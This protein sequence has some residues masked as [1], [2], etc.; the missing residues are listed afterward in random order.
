MGA[1]WDKDNIGQYSFAAGYGTLARGVGS[2]SMGA[3]NSSTGSY[4]VSLGADNSSIGDASVSFGNLNLAN[5]K[6][7]MVIGQSSWAKNDFSFCGGFQSVA[8]GDYSISYGYISYATGLRSI[9]LG[10]KNVARGRVQLQWVAITKAIGGYA[11]SLGANSTASGLFSATLGSVN[12]ALG[13]Y[14][15]GLGSENTAVADYSLALGTTNVT[16]GIHSATLGYGNVA[17][18]SYSLV[19]GSYN[20]STLTDKYFEIGNGTFAARSNAFTVLKNGNVG[21]GITNPTNLLTFAAIGGKKISLFP[22]GTG[23]AG[24]GIFPNEFRQYSDNPNADITFG[25]DSYSTGFSEKV[26]FKASGM[27]GVGTATPILSTG[28]SGMVVQNNTYIQMRVQSSASAAGMEFKPS[29]GN[30]Y[31]IQADNSNNWFVYNRNANAYRLFINGSGF[32]GIGTNNPTQALQ[33]IGNILASGTITPSDI[34][35]KKNIQLIESPMEKLKQLNGVTYEYR[36][37][38]FPQMGF[39]DMEQVGL[40]AQEVEKVF[41]QLVVTDDKGYKAV[42]YVKLVPVLIE[43]TKAQQSQ[44]DKQQQQIEE[45]QKLVKQLMHSK[46]R[47]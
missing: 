38:D 9:S 2:V 5:G 25:Y 44:I 10:D 22:G 12:V 36:K 7:S 30:Q 1:T 15:I 6:Y 17:Q 42:D 29:T 27:V 46:T 28:A 8:S 40:I 19:I 24:M 3:N 33:V 20:D 41:P 23:D 16:R 4:T 32:V 47:E 39:S 14:S 34:R 35:Y 13:N 21:I 18:S 31:E 45:L 37:D 11:T 43:S 26:R